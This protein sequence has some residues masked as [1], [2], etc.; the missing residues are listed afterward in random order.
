MTA[1]LLISLIAATVAILIWSGA[2]LLRKRED[3]LAARLEELQAHA[4]ST[5]ARR[6]VRRRGGFLNAVLNA[7]G[8]VPGGEQ[9]LRDTELEL[10]QAGMRQRWALGAYALFQVTFLLIA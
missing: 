2:E 7:I 9:W 4:M 3:P 5:G 6:P 1:L 10:A 8:F